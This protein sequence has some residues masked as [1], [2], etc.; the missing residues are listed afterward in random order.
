M[1][2]W[3][4]AAFIVWMVIFCSCSPSDPTGPTA[5]RWQSDGETVRR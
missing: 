3:T 2:R 4:L 1:T 5:H